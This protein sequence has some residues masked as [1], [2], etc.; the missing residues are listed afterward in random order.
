MTV[1]RKRSTKHENNRIEPDALDAELYRIGIAL[2]LLF[3]TIL[4]KNQAVTAKKG[5]G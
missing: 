4:Q 2:R 5:A 1:H 3:E